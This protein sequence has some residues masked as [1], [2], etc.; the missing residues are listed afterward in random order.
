MYVHLQKYAKGCHDHTEIRHVKS[1]R[2]CVLKSI[3]SV[4][5]LL[6]DYTS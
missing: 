5:A 4:D 6:L 2:L 3:D 1:T